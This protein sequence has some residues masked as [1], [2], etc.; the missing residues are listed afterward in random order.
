MTPTNKRGP[1]L[2][3]LSQRFKTR[4]DCIQFLESLRWPNGPVC[5][6]CKHTSAM[7]I[8]T[9]LLWECYGCGHQF[10]VTAGTIMHR[11]HLPLPKWILAACLIC[12]AKKGISAKQIERDLS[13]TY[14]TAWYLMHRIRKAMKEPGLMSKFTGIVEIDE[15]YLGG[16]A[17]GKRGR[18]AANKT[19]VLGIRER[20]GGVRTE[21]PP[22]L[23]MKTI[24]KLVRKHVSTKAMMV[25]TDDLSS[26]DILARWYEPHK[27]NHS[28]GEYVRELAHTNSMESFWNV[29]KRGIIGSYHKVSVG[30]LPLYLNEFCYRFA[31][32]R[33]GNGVG[34]WEEVLGN[35][36]AAKWVTI[37]SKCRDIRRD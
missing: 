30:Y 37:P 20:G 27:V 1:S 17:H 18:G 23:K 35:A 31:H 33:N 21:M 24:S 10:S 36:L 22:D 7:R 8:H 12:N 32:T 3:E 6:K 15:T 5:P 19:V 13:V 14:K 29:L 28:K 4:K 9:R 16:K 26:Y 2:Y 34:L 11:S 25:C